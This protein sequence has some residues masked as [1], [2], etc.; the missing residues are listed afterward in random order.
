MSSSLS[1]KWAALSILLGGYSPLLD[2]LRNIIEFL[3]VHYPA[4]IRPVNIKIVSFS[5]K[6]SL[7]VSHWLLWLLLKL[8]QVSFLSELYPYI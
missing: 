6:S 1:F 4:T 8:S 3:A 5:T 2:H 7:K